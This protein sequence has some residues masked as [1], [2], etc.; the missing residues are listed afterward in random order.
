MS[1]TSPS[2][3]PSNPSRSQ[4]GALTSMSSRRARMPQCAGVELATAAVPHLFLPLACAA[5][6]VKTPI[7]KAFAEGENIGDVT[8]K[9]EYSKLPCYLAPIHEGYH[10][11]LCVVCP[12]IN[13]VYW[14]DSM[15]G[16]PH[17]DIKTMFSN[18]LK[19]YRMIAGIK[20]GPS[21]EP[22]WVYPICPRQPG[23]TECGYYVM[24]YMYSI[25]QSGH[26]SDFDKIF[27]I[28]DAY[29]KEEINLVRNLLAGHL[30]QHIDN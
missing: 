13:T 17:R 8:A 29:S 24:L 21:R 19:A 12:P 28:N 18:A 9:G 10:Y 23:D 7:Y 1:A 30:L 2:P 4:S 5:N 25:I 14:F 22:A 15:G 26:T 11:S 6:V 3:P 20:V 27:G 16:R